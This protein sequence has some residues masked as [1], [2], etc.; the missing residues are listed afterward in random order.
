LISLYKC[1]KL[2]RQTPAQ[3]A[4]AILSTVHVFVML[5]NDHRVNV[6]LG[7]NYKLENT[8]GSLIAAIFEGLGIAPASTS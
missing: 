4:L 7:N 8:S 2:T 1:L 6:L 3:Q 5:V